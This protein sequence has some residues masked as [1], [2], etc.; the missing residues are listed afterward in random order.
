MIMHAVIYADNHERDAPNSP[1]MFCNVFLSGACFGIAQGDRLSMQVIA[2]FTVYDIFFSF[3]GKAVIYSG[4]NPSIADAKKI[5]FE[6]CEKMNGFFDCKK[7][8]LNDGRIEFVAQRD[9]SSEFIH[10]L[11]SPGKKEFKEINSFFL[12]IKSCDRS[13]NTLR[14]FQ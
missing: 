12:N 8:K 6:K 7:R 9:E 2:D 13:T 11:F 1:Y 14:C 5:P 10:V 4:F 3:G